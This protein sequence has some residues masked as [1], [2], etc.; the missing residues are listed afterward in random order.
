MNADAVEHTARQIKSN[1][2]GILVIIFHKLFNSNANSI[3]VCANIASGF[4]LRSRMI[5]FTTLETRVLKRTGKM[6]NEDECNTPTFPE[7]IVADGLS[8]SRPFNMPSV[9]ERGSPN[10]PDDEAVVDY[11]KKRVKNQRER[12]LAQELTFCVKSNK[13]AHA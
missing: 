10:E 2:A 4:T 13:P 7:T 1:L 5:S 8:D 6:N 12:N 3:R 9:G 11:V